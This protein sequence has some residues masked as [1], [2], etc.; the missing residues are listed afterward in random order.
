MLN[1]LIKHEMR[2]TAK[3]F[4]WLYIAFAV[5]AVVNTLV[6]PAST[7]YGGSSSS[8]GGYNA[9]TELLPSALKVI[10][11]ILYGLSFA[12]MVIVTLVVV[13][14]RF[15]R[16][17]LGDEGYLMMTLPVS[18]E[19][20]ILSKLFVAVIWNVCTCVL[21]FLSILLAIASTG[22]FSEVVKWIQ[23]LANEGAPVDRWITM[24]VISLIVSCFMGVLMLYAAMATG[25]NLLKNRVG[26]SILA[27]III[28]IVSQIITF[29]IIYGSVRGF[30]DT[31]AVMSMPDASWS[32][33][34]S[35][36]ITQQAV[37]AIE[38]LIWSCIVGS[39]VIAAGCWFLTRFMLR[40]KL[41]LA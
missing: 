39:G 29:A 17:L 19:K 32:P 3:T 31:G 12:A 26:G 24:L 18:R 21:I 35:T 41:N 28:Y 22:H 14:Q 2:A 34:G 7:I 4:M 25:P 5:I 36:Y 40:R 27:F 20:H 11:G 6:N 8:T 10:V 16:N 23:D 13:I 9:M 38:F 30:I 1:T 37:G 15:Y 33:V